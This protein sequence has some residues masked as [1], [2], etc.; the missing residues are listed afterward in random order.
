[1]ADGSPSASEHAD[2]RVWDLHENEVTQLH[3]DFRFT[4]ICY[5][6]EDSG[7]SSSLTVVIETPFIW[8]QGGRDVWCNPENVETV[9]PLLEILH[10]PIAS[11]VAF[12]DG[13]L[14]VVFVDGDLIILTKDPSYES[15]SAFGTGAMADLQ[16]LCSPH[17]G[18]PWAE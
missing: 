15:W 5:W 7:Q 14:H 17:D 12:R 8:R 2:H 3:I 13:R 1:M 9:K 11:L 6:P 18:S 10:K 4:L 16:L